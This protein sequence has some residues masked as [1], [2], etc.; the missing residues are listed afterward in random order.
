MYLGWVRGGVI[1]ATSAGIAFVLPSF[2]MVIGLASIYAHFGGPWI[3]GAF[4]GV[5][6]AVIAVIARSVVKLAKMTLGRDVLLWVL[7]AASAAVTAITESEMVWLLIASG[8]VAML[9]KAPPR[10][11]RGAAAMVAPAFLWTGLHGPASGATLLRIAWFFTKAGA[12]VFGSGLAI[13]PFLYSGV[14]KEYGWLDEQQFRDAVAVAMITPGP[15]VV[16]A[17]FIGYLVGGGVGALL[18]AGGTFVP[19]YLVVVVAAKHMRKASQNASLKA[20]IAGITASATG[21]IAGGA[22][23]LGRRAILDA[24]TVLIAIATFVALV[25][26]RRVPEPVLIAVAAAVGLAV[27]H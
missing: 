18:A 5:G 23:V 10:M 25:A 24:T 6:A 17:G 19:P 16:T 22:F 2:L 4:Y 11:G 15:V 1:G 8:I 13:V 27:H 21:A 14:V 26:V 7:C 9:V 12:F 3:Q 20:C